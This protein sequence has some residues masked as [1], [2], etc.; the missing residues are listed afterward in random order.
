MLLLNTQSFAGP[1]KAS[2]PF[3]LSL[4]TPKKFFVV[5]SL[6]FILQDIRQEELGKLLSLNQILHKCEARL[7]LH[8]NGTE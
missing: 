7:R 4:E 3:L 5:Y 8:K 2:T 6:R 1:F